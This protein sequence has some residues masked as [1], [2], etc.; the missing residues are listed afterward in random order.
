MLRSY[1]TDYQKFDVH[2]KF[3]VEQRK[4]AWEIRVHPK[5]YSR[6]GGKGLV[7]MREIR[8]QDLTGIHTWELKRAIHNTKTQ[9]DQ[10]FEAGMKLRR[11]LSNRG[12]SMIE[13][14]LVGF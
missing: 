6:R 11:E 3:S 1:Y 7:L 8:E 9:A 2:R 14:E 4:K 12:E 5:K 10:L 13:I